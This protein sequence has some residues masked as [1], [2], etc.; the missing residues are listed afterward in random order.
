[1][2]RIKEREELKRMPIVIYTGKELS[3]AED[4]QLRR[5]AETII[6]KDVRSPERLLDETALF[7]HRVEA[8][9]PEAKRRM[10]ERLHNADAVFAGE[11]NEHLFY[12]V[13]KAKL[14]SDRSGT[15][16]VKNR[17]LVSGGG[18]AVGA[19]RGGSWR[20]SGGAAPEQPRRHAPGEAL[21]REHVRRL[22]VAERSRP[23]R[24]QGPNGD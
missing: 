1:M 15:H 18:T 8:E 24:R 20:D 2:K 19:R 5:Y 22:G 23:H 6:V 21:H 10:L 9:L 11:V 16:A 7:L 4:T 14:A 3:Q 13:V 17:S 12:E